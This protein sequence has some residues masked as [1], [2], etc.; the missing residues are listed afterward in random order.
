MQGMF[1][2]ILKIGIEGDDYDTEFPRKVRFYERVGWKCLLAPKNEN[3]S[4]EWEYGSDPTNQ[5]MYC[6]LNEC[7]IEDSNI[8]L[9]A[10][11]NLPFKI[12]DEN[13]S[14]HGDLCH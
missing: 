13:R 6:E 9:I 4:S 12:H 14:L 11:N 8:K 3:F 10:R 1:F 5:W 7:V 2:G